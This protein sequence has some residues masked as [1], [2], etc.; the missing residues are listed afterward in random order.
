MKLKITAE[1]SLTTTHKFEV[2]A[3]P[4][5]ADFTGNQRE[6]FFTRI[7]NAYAA[8]LDAVDFRTDFADAKREIDVSNVEELLK[9]G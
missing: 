6:E 8:S 9:A 5:F 7:G 3:P 1:V 4:G 2:E